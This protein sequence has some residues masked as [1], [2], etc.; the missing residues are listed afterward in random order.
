MPARVADLPAAVAGL[1]GTGA[2][3]GVRGTCGLMWVE[4]PDAPRFLQGLLSNDLAAL[5]P[6]EAQR[7]LLLDAKGHIVCDLRLHRDGDDAFTLVATTAAVEVLA[8]AL[9]R[10]HFSEDLELLGPEPS[11]LVTVPGDRRPAGALVLP[12]PVPGTTDLVVADAAAALDELGLAEAPAEALEVLRVER[13]VPM[14]GRDTG[15]RTLVQEAGLEDVA[16]SFTKGCYL[17]QETVARVQHRGRV[18][19]GV[20]GLRAGTPLPEGAEVSSGDRVIGTVGSAACSPAFGHIALA[21]LRRDVPAGTEV[22]VEGLPGP[23]TVCEVP[24]R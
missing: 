5:A 20:R 13:G 1:A 8:E 2:P 4:G 10:Y 17:G 6:G 15:P 14:T 19:R 22:V 18:H 24:F 12:G 3:A 9:A 21:V 11:D 23:A 7:T 16:V